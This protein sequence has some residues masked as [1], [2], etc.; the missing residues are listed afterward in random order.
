MFSNGLKGKV[1]LIELE[2]IS[3]EITE[4]VVK[5]KPRFGTGNISID[6]EGKWKWE[7]TNYDTSR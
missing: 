1:D 7:C 3:K 4:K 2:K 5:Q 6:I